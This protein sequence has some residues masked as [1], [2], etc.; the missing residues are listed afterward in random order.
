MDGGCGQH[1]GSGAAAH[2]DQITG[3]F[4]D[5]CAFVNPSRSAVAHK[6]I[7]QLLDAEKIV[8]QDGQ[9]IPALLQILP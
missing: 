4:V 2:Q 6:A 9:L 5:S 3:S 7:S 8:D 1:P